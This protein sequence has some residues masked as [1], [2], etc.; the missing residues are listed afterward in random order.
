MK[1]PMASVHQWSPTW[2]DYSKSLYHLPLKNGWWPVFSAHPQTL[3]ISSPPTTNHFKVHGAVF[4]GHRQILTTDHWPSAACIF[5]F[6]KRIFWVFIIDV[7]KLWIDF[8]LC[9]R[10][11]HIQL[12][13]VHVFVLTGFFLPILAV[14]YKG[15]LAIE[16]SKRPRYI[17]LPNKPCGLWKIWLT[18]HSPNS[19]LALMWEWKRERANVQEEL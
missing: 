2:F 7:N 10:Y 15:L 9:P 6:F 19:S 5:W 13:L 16:P 3:I 17:S 8:R 1:W 4:S 14:K 12:Q 11:F 18:G